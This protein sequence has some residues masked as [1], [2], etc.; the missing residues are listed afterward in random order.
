MAWC[1]RYYLGM[2]GPGSS[3]PLQ[4]GLVTVTAAA[5]HSTIITLPFSSRLCPVRMRLYWLLSGTL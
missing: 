3:D 5:V 1:T 2:D 4:L